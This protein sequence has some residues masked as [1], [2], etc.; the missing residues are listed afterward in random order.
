MRASRY[1]LNIL[2]SVSLSPAQFLLRLRKSVIS[3]V[4]QDQRYDYFGGGNCAK[5]VI[6]YIAIN[7]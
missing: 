5:R 4:R 7:E 2:D 3:F 1:E 6:R